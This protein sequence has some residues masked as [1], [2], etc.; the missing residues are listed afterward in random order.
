[1]AKET[2]WKLQNQHFW[3]ITVKTHAGNKPFFWIV[4]GSP[5]FLGKTLVATFRLNDNLIFGPNLL[6]KTIS[7]RE[8]KM[9]TS[10]FNSAYS[11]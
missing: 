6:K 5:Q 4:R 3:A 11:N 2:V 1:M 10:P 8:L 9:G 7:G